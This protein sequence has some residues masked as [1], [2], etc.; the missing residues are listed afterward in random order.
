MPESPT[1]VQPQTPPETI[2][3]QVPPQTPGVAGMPAPRAVN[4]R[5]DTEYALAAGP[6]SSRLLDLMERAV[7][8]RGCFRGPAEMER[9]ARSD[10]SAAKAV[11]VLVGMALA[12]GVNVLPAF[13]PPL[14]PPVT[15]EVPGDATGELRQETPEQRQALADYERQRRRYETAVEIRD[16]CVASLEQLNADLPPFPDALEDQARSGVVAGFSIAEQVFD[17]VGYGRFRD[18][19]LH[20]RYA[21]RPRGAVE[22]VLDRHGRLLGYVPRGTPN[23]ADGIAQ[24]LIDPR[25]FTVFTPRPRDG[26]IRG[27]SYLEAAA[28][29]ADVRAHMWPEVIRYAMTVAFNTIIA[30]APDPKL[31]ADPR[32]TEYEAGPGGVADRTK[33]IPLTRSI[34][35]TLGDLDSNSIAVVPHG[36]EINWGNIAAEGGKAFDA[37]FQLMSNE[38][39]TSVLGALVNQ[40]LKGMDA[41]AGLSVIEVLVYG[42]RGKLAR[43]IRD[44]MFRTLLWVNYGD[45]AYEFLPRVSMG[46]TERRNFKD[47]TSAFAAVG[48]KLH[49][50]QYQFVD[51]LLGAPIRSDEA[52]QEEM[53]IRRL[54]LDA[55]RQAAAEGRDPLRP[56]ARPAAGTG[57]RQTGTTGDGTAEPGRIPVTSHER[58]APTRRTTEE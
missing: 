18:R 35:R 48:Y 30:V 2:R 5:L 28:T 54:Q 31:H 53:S 36:T 15:M 3:A 17:K 46:D 52:V 33:P 11:N 39:E 10:A 34:A 23:T 9:I 58:R 45:E 22:P 37:L 42:V 4:V 16:L 21:V 32:F 47:D 49:P 50:S 13:D 38:I 6:R 19:S 44:Q 14:R 55:Q 43:M 57:A 20:T 26:D 1:T 25:K 51:A 24:R 29:A 27:A 56:N 7:R 40:V 8:D 12:D 41:E